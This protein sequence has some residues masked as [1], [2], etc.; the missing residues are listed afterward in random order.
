[1][2]IEVQPQGTST[3]HQIK[4]SPFQIVCQV[5]DTVSANTIISGAGSIGTVA[6]ALTDFT[7]TLFDSGNNQR[8][9]GGDQV[10]VTIEPTP[11]PGSPVADVEVFD[12][13]D[14][15]YRVRYVINDASTAYE[16]SVRANGGTAVKQ[17]P[18]LTVVSST[19]SPSLSVLQWEGSDWAPEN[20][21][22]I[23]L[24][25]DYTHLTFIK[26]AYLNAVKENALTLVTEVEGV[27][28][29]LYFTATVVDQTEG[30]YSTTFSVP[31]STD[32]S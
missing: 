1:M 7:V 10:A 2:T 16:I 27:G 29:K 17:V 24:L 3:Y 20:V 15:T 32:R 9:S 21:P 23:R 5:T 6:G 31:S 26:D 13:H 25:N 18:T 28:Q 11:G 4:G 22:I 8:T 19:P 12:N 30:K 14:G